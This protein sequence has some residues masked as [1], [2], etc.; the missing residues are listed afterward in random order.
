MSQLLEEHGL[1]LRWQTS[2]RYPLRDSYMQYQES[3]FDTVQRLLAEE[4]VFF[5]HEHGDDAATMVLADDGGAYADSKLELHFTRDAERS[6]LA[7]GDSLLAFDPVHRARTKEVFARR[8]D[9]GRPG[10]YLDGSAKLGSAAEVLSGGLQALAR[11]HRLPRLPAETVYDHGATF[12]S[13]DR[14]REDARVML[15]QFRRDAWTA[16]G[17]SNGPHLAVGAEARILDHPLEQLNGTYPIV[18]IRHALESEGGDQTYRNEFTVVRGGAPFRPP[19]PRARRVDTVELATVQGDRLGT[20]RTDELGRVKVRFHW[21]R[22]E[23]EEPD[24]CWVR[25]AQSW[26]G[27]GWG[28]QFIP[29]SG[30]E[31]LVGFVG[32]DPDQPVVLGSV[33]NGVRPHP[34]PTTVES[35]VSGF[36]TQT[37][38]DDGGYNEVALEDTPGAQ[39]LR[40]RAENELVQ[41]SNGD[42]VRWVGGSERHN[43]VHDHRSEIGGDSNAVIAGAAST[44]VTGEYR[45]VAHGA[46]QYRYENRLEETVAGAVVRTGD[47]VRVAASRNMMQS[48]REISLI[49]GEPGRPGYGS[50][51]VFGDGAFTATERMT[52]RG[53]RELIFQSGE[54]TIRLS[55]EGIELD[56]PKI[57]IRGERRTVVYGGGATVGLT[58]S[59]S[60]AGGEVLVSS[61]GASMVLDANA[62]L[63]GALVLLNCG[64]ASGG[65]EADTTEIE[66]ETLGLVMLKPSGEPFGGWNY[67]LAAGGRRRKGRPTRLGASTN[68]CR[69][70]AVEDGY[71]S[72]TRRKRASSSS[73]CSSTSSLRSRL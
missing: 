50:F 31:V 40:L 4:G 11:T 30:M 37:D 17:R 42:T 39:Q 61:K 58:G 47:E 67:E 71:V 73:T 2:R 16:E 62:A 15:E 3:D 7:S 9:I 19:P 22:L 66:D 29:R 24:A 35:T 21:E 65:A 33:Y 20:M 44:S 14:H 13:G 23:G 27:T 5:W 53:E 48:A 59:V 52:L 6:A 55:D 8:Y 34:F 1:T 18:A 56:A 28:S 32:G 36:R 41:R 51:D 60:V 57:T 25:V 12:R 70:G 46:A 68:P 69:E 63:D 64:G 49:A 43:V 26:A 10:A 54:S 72:R 38:G 45:V